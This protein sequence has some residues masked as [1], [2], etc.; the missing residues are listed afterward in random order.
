MFID[1]SGLRIWIAAGKQESNFH[2]IFS[3]DKFSPDKF[4]SDKFLSD[5]ILYQIKDIM[6]TATRAKGDYQQVMDATMNYL[7]NLNLPQ[8]LKRK[9]KLWF[10][11]TW[12][13]QKT[14]SEYGIRRFFR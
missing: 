9:I 10:T 11:Y 6:A 2:Q 14:L 4:S 5:T 1:Y 7:R 8:S 12:Q 13:S 3:S